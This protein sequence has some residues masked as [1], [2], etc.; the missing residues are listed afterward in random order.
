[1]KLLLKHKIDLLF[2]IIILILFMLFNYNFAV[3]HIRGTS[4]Y[5]TYNDGNVLLLRKNNLRQKEDIIVFKAPDS[6]DNYGA[7]F[8]KRIIAIENDVIE[9]DKNMV[10]INGKLITHKKD[11]ICDFP[12]VSKKFILKKG[13]YFVMG[14][15]IENSNDSL[16]QYC[17]G[18]ENFLIQDKDVKFTGKEI[19]LYK[20]VFN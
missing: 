7:M 9:I 3:L 14:D 4:M 5:P 2:I 16:L 10:K 18:N 20:G 11:K 13:E 12:D 1:M 8:I 17:Q 15:N 6:W 19:F